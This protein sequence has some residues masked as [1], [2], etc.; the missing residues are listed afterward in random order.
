MA[1]A[2]EVFRENGLKVAQ[3]T[4]AEA[5]QVLANQAERTAS[6]VS[7]QGMWQRVRVKA[8]ARL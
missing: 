6:T 8:E 2:V 4:E 7:R 1:R 3:M 5:A